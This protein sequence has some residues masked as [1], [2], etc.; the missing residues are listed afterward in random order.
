VNI[1]ID[2]AGVFVVQTNR[3]QYVCCLVALMIPASKEAETFYDFLRLR[4]QWKRPQIEVKGSSLSESEIAEVVDLLRTR[5]VTA[6]V[7]A[8]DMARHTDVA[9]STFKQAQASVLT[10]GLTPA[11]HPEFVRGAEALRARWLALPNQLFVQSFMVIG[12]IRDLLQTATLYYSQRLPSELARF[13]WVI[14]AKDKNITEMEKIWTTVI[15]P[16]LETQ[17]LTQPWLFL[18]DADYSHFQR[19]MID[20]TTSDQDAKRHIDWL[21]QRTN[22]GHKFSGVDARPLM[23]EDRRFADSRN[24]L[25]LQLA[26][27]VASAFYRALNGTLVRQGWECLGQLLIARRPAALHFVELSPDTGKVGIRIIDHPMA[28]I[29]QHIERSARS[30]WAR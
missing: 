19:F 29:V 2:E 15:A 26:D 6:E 25:G 16:I 5:E 28:D 10:K 3:P 18:I 11:H 12:L 30:M 27:V 24:E 4:D 1:Y 22:Q 7:V 23:E 9:I 20:E 17:A 21:S 8:I 14:D 13:R